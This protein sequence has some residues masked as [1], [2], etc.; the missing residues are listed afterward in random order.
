MFHGVSLDSMYDLPLHYLQSMVQGIEWDRKEPRGTVVIMETVA[1]K[2]FQDC[3][4]WSGKV[5]C[6]PSMFHPAR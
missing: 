6:V 3:I 1:G 2:G 5:Q 4:E